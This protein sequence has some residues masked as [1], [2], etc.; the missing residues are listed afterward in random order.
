MSSQKP[1][2]SK[3]KSLLSW[4]RPRDNKANVEDEKVENSCTEEMPESSSESGQDDDAAAD[5]SEA[6]GYQ[7]PLLGDRNAGKYTFRCFVFKYF[8]GGGGGWGCVTPTPP[9]TPH[10]LSRTGLYPSN[11]SSEPQTPNFQ[12][13]SSNLCAP[14]VFPGLLRPCHQL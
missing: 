8:H 13:T 2:K 12:N 1:R 7:L 4:V 14:S 3:Q 5:P 11:A 9:V 10:S 6:L